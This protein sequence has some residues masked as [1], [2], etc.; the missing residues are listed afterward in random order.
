MGV[1]RGLVTR[2][3]KLHVPKGEGGRSHANKVHCCRS[4]DTYYHEWCQLTGAE[5]E[6]TSPQL[7]LRLVATLIF[8]PLC[9]YTLSP[10]HVPPSNTSLNV[11]MLQCSCHWRWSQGKR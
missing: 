4:D 5:D 3:V 11:Q 8:F 10:P 7:H 6:Y 1:G 2:C 9:E